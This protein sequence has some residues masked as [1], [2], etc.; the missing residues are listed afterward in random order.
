M[1][2]YPGALPVSRV[3]IGGNFSKL[4]SQPLWVTKHFLLQANLLVFLQSEKVGH[5]H[6]INSICPLF[7][8]LQKLLGLRFQNQ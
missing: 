6:L 1:P 5:M 3:P 7:I 8:R 4:Q 2:V